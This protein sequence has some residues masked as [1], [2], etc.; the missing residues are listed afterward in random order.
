MVTFAVNQTIF[1]VCSD[2]KLKVLDVGARHA[3]PLPRPFTRRGEFF[4]W[5]SV[6]KVVS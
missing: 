2:T 1:A 4:I 3:S 6:F 5:K